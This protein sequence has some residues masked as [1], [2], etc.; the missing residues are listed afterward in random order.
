MAICPAR[1]SSLC[2]TIGFIAARHMPLEASRALR[3]Y[4]RMRRFIV[5]FIAV[6]M[7][8]SL[9]VY[10]LCLFFTT[11]VMLYVYTF[12]CT[13]N[14]PLWIRHSFCGFLTEIALRLESTGR[15]FQE[16]YEKRSYKKYI[17]ITLLF[18]NVD[19]LTLKNKFTYVILV[20]YSR[21]ISSLVVLF[22]ITCIRRVFHISFLFFSKVHI[23]PIEYS[24][25]LD[26][27]LEHWSIRS[28]SL[29]LLEEIRE[30]CENITYLRMYLYGE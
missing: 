12:V 2:C 1:S 6:T 20:L 27:C 3:S 25:I 24:V 11:V 5:F 8:D 10:Y 30:L 4:S 23:P 22:I 21:I 18:L 9:I 14:L 13:I 17:K 16:M 29:F 15:E 19:C 7:L 28:L 26:W